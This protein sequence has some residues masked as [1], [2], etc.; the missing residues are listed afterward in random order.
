MSRKNTERFDGSM[1]Q[2]QLERAALLA[3]SRGIDL[4]TTQELVYLRDR[5][6]DHERIVK[7]LEAV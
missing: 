5:Y 7:E 1:T 2:E 6:S 4:E 3:E